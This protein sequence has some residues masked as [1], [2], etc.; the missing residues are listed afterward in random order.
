MAQAPA[1]DLWVRTMEQC[2]KLPYYSDYV[3]E[4]HSS[5]STICTLNYDT[6]VTAGAAF[7]ELLRCY[8]WKLRFDPDGN[9]VELPEHIWRYIRSYA[10][11]PL[12]KRCKLFFPYASRTALNQLII[13]VTEFDASDEKLMRLLDD[14]SNSNNGPPSYVL[15]TLPMDYTDVSPRLMLLCDVLAKFYAD[16]HTDPAKSPFFTYGRYCNQTTSLNLRRKDGTIQRIRFINQGCNYRHSK[17]KTVMR[18]LRIRGVAVENHTVHRG[19][20]IVS[21]RGEVCTDPD[22][23]HS[24]GGGYEVTEL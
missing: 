1:K 6:Y 4:G 19:L 24:C 11:D 21:H 12:P 9:E 5:F 15:P 2:Y 16:Y 20:R 8:C 22:D 23:F 7:R 13:K 17:F 10:M 18:A 14:V 3:F